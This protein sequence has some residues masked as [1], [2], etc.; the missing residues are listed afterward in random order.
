MKKIQPMH[1]GASLVFFGIPATVLFIAT[2]W[3]VSF[4]NRLTGLPQVVCWFINGGLLVFIPLLLASL[5]GFYFEGNDFSWS[6]IR[7]RFR[8]ET[9]SGRDLLWLLGGIVFIGAVTQFLVYLGPR[10]FIHFST[11]PSFMTM[12]PLKPDEMWILLAWGPLF[13]FNI[14]G[15]ELFWRGYILPRQ[16][17]AYGKWAWLVHGS[18]WWMF[19]FA[20]GWQ[21]MLILAPLLFTLPYIVQKRKNTWIGI[22]IHGLINGGGFIAVALGSLP[23]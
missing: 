4:L 2:H 22:L 5:G 13:I 12:K 16:E 23:S 20:F 9:I 3:G 21:L 19:H 1:L 7:S 6:S 17:L 10:I 15:E 14:L 18:L 8:L 11:N